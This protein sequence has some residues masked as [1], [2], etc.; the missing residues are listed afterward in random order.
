MGREPAPGRVRG[1]ATAVFFALGGSILL[2]PGDAGS[3][4]AEQI[5]PGHYSGGGFP[6]TPVDFG[7]SADRHR[8]KSFT[9]RVKMDCRHNGQFLG[10][11]TLKRIVFRPIPIHRTA[12]GGRFDRTGRGRFT[13]GGRF[14]VVVHGILIAP[15]RARGKIR[16]RARLPGDVVC[17]PAFGPIGWT[18]R[19]V[20]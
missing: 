13:G 19:F 11:L 20:G 15:E 18:A 10:E 14:K 16:A 1:A 2:L 8:V 3:A 5:H 17:V 6:S 4:P 9:T 7:V 12:A